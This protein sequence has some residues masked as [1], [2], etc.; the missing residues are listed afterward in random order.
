MAM[1]AAS[2]APLLLLG[3]DLAVIA[4]SESFT[5][6]FGIDPGA[7]RGRKLCELGRGDWGAPQLRSLLSAAVSTDATIDDYEMDLKI[8]RKAPRRLLVRAQ[9]LD[10]GDAANVRLL[11]TISDVTAARGG[12]ALIEDIQ[13]KNAVLVQEVQNRVANSLQIIASLLMLSARRLQSDETRNHLFDAHRRV[14]SIATVQRRLALSALGRVELRAYLT[15]LC[16][17]LGGSM[18]PDSGQL[19]LTVAADDSAA[20]G[21]VSMSL[22]LI[23]TELVINALKHA[24]PDQRAGKIDVDYRSRGSAWKLSVRDDGVGM[25]AGAQAGLGTGIVEALAKHLDARVQIANARPGTTVSIIHGM[26]ARRA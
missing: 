17:S 25:P 18:I 1:V 22:G 13:R 6:G 26:M 5:K 20:C 12:A 19:S 21:D 9:R 7:V 8:G 16:Q 24:F 15:N 3:G 4:A 14:M 10:Y 11:V 2:A 23:V